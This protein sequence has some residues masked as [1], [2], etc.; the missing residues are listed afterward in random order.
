MAAA[1]IFS[2]VVRSPMQ[3]KEKR[4]NQ[5]RRS[6]TNWVDLYVYVF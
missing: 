4:G 1:L 2:N 3:Q 6:N 5:S